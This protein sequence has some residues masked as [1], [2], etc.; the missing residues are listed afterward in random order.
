[1]SKRAVATKPVPPVPPV[2]KCGHQ[3]VMENLIWERDGR[4]N[5][6]LGGRWRCRLCNRAKVAAWAQR[7]PERMAERNQ[8]Y[9]DTIP[10][11]LADL[12]AQ[13]NRSMRRHAFLESI[14]GDTVVTQEEEHP[15]VK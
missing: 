1:M 7:Y 8:R 14:S 2:M 15:H 10:G 12:Q 13:L 5:R 4:V 6:N 11:M 3:N 9:R